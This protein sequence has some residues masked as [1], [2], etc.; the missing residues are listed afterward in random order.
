MIGRAGYK[1]MTFYYPYPDY[2]FPM[3]IYSDDYLPKKGELSRNNLN[4]DREKIYMF[5]ESKVFDQV[6]EEGMFPF[7]SNSFLVEA[8]VGE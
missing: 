1:D 8:R 4:F 5:D 7:F 2:K 3:A 6:L